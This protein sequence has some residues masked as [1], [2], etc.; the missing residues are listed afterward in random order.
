MPLEDSDR[1][2]R[3][4][5][6]LHIPTPLIG[7]VVAI[8]VVLL[9]TYKG[10]SDSLVWLG[11]MLAI[12]AGIFFLSHPSV[13]LS[14][15]LVVSSAKIWLPFLPLD[16]PIDILMRAC[17][18][19]AV[20]AG[21][22]IRKDVQRGLVVYRPLAYAFI[23]LVFI[24]IVRRGSG[25]YQLGGSLWGGKAYIILLVNLFFLLIIPGTLTMTRRGWALTLTF[26]LL[27]PVVVVCA[28]A[29]YVLS[30]GRFFLLYWLFRPTS[31]VGLTAF[32]LGQQDSGVWRLQSFSQL[33]FSWVAMLLFPWLRR[34]PP[35]WILAGLL[36]VLH[37]LFT[38][39]SGFRAALAMIPVYLATY[40]WLAFPR[41]R[42]RLVALGLAM[43]CAGLVGAYTLVPHLPTPAQR[44][45]SWLPGIEVNARVSMD[46]DHSSNWRLD[47]W[48]L[49]WHREVPKHWLTG[50]GL[51]YHP[52]HLVDQSEVQVDYWVEL[53]NFVVLGEYHNGP[54]SLLVC[55]GIWGLLLMVALFIAAW[56][57]C[58]AQARREW[59]DPYL[60][61]FH[62]V[63][64]SLYAVGVLAFLFI[65][66]DL[67][68]SLQNLLTLVVIMELLVR[69]DPLLSKPP[70]DPQ[71][72]RLVTRPPAKAAPRIA[73]PTA[74]HR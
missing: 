52:A 9:L 14:I 3:P 6:T 74:L 49:I 13:F 53:H 63:C 70:V 68:Y 56:R 2:F 44:A 27:A 71:V 51:A 59:G 43:L 12:P 15:L 46:A 36:V 25:F 66:G 48:S 60:R 5:E 40:L 72:R 18:L 11:V 10:F 58:L 28:D 4:K 8:A 26:M 7:G 67:Q 65:Y 38:A 73:M 1:P 33:K 24:T 32:E 69:S 29:L 61:N 41:R 62:L 47:L 17:L 64:F 37:L 20:V 22:I 23:C 50:K 42:K 57:R 31:S 39:L 30:G 16:L 55:F 35:G 45:L 54:L 19:A 34:S 21:A